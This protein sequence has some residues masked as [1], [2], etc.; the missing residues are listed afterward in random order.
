MQG[1]W[2]KAVQGLKRLLLQECYLGSEDVTCWI[3]GAGQLIA[4]ANKA[5]FFPTAVSGHCAVRWLQ[6]NRPRLARE[7]GLTE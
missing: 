6:V 5:V 4:L 2:R 7:M 1:P 3:Y